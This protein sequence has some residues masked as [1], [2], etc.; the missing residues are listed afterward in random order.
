[1]NAAEALAWCR[2]ELG[3]VED[4]ESL[5]PIEHGFTH[6]DLRLQPLRVRFTT[7]SRVREADDRIWYPLRSPPKVGLPRP[8]HQLFERMRNAGA[9]A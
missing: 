5:P 7:S 1:V 9:V 2:R 6:F 3:D 4:M 8:I